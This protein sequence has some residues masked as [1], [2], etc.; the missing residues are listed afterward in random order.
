MASTRTTTISIRLTPELLARIQSNAEH[1]G[2]DRNGYIVSWLNYAC[3]TTC[4]LEGET[5]TIYKRRVTRGFQLAHGSEHSLVGHDPRGS[6][7]HPVI[8]PV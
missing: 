6:L 1:A 3:D 4:V 7:A 8:R 5:G 2:Q